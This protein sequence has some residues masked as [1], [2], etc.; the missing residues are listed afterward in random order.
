MI[1]VVQLT[2]RARKELKKVPLHVAIKLLSWVALVADKGLEEVRRV[3]GY[4]DEPL[5]GQRAGERSIRLS[6]WQFRG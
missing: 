2:D 4:H 3:P 6:S 1:R 5:H